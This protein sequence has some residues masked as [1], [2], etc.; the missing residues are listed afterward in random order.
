MLS[1][2]WCGCVVSTVCLLRHQKAKL[3]GCQSEIAELEKALENSRKGRLVTGRMG[4]CYHLQWCACVT[5]L[6]PH[7]HPTLTHPVEQG[8]QGEGDSL[9]S[10]MKELK[11]T[12]SKSAKYEARQKIH[13]LRKVSLWLL[14]LCA[15]QGAPSSPHLHTSCLPSLPFS[16]S[17]TLLH[18]PTSPPSSLSSY[19]SS[20]LPPPP[21][22]SLLSSRPHSLP[23]SLSHSLTHSFSPISS[24]SPVPPSLPSFLCTPAVGRRILLETDQHCQTRWDNPLHK[25]PHAPPT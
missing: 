11:G 8:P 16:L 7:S 19:L 13:H 22:L 12:L 1:V 21:S 25:V 15:L 4:H 17:P 20:S 14:A 3:E 6:S 2:L 5:P 24:I 9:D 18:L 23:P 10:F